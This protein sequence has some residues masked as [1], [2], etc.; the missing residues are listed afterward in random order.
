MRYFAWRINLF[1]ISIVHG[2]KIWG[3]HV[4]CAYTASHFLQWSVPIWKLEVNTQAQ[5]QKQLLLKSDVTLNS[6]HHDEALNKA[7][8]SAEIT[9]LNFAVIKLASSALSV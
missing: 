7:I 3:T 5:S 9:L 8:G 4:S 6:I 2:A 1:H